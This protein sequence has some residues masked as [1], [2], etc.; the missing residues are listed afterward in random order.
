MLNHDQ[1]NVKKEYPKP[2]GYTADIAVFTIVATEKEAYKPPKMVLK[3]M[4]IQRA[5][6]NAEGEQNIEAGKWALPGGFVH[7]AES[8]YEAAKRELEEE[9][10]VAGIHMKQYGV[11][12]KPGRDARGWVISNAHYAIVPEE[13]LA[14]RQANDDAANV[15]LFDLEEVFSLPLAFDHAQIIQDGIAEIKK[16]L[17]Q[18]TVA[19]KFLPKMFTYSE[20]QAVLLTITDNPAIRSDQA[21]ARKIRMLPFIEEVEGQTT[22]RTS[23][24]PTKLYRFIDADFATSIYTARY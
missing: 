19:Q 12:D 13:M 1:K 14:K 5:I 3:L 9:T 10:G 15:E 6:L 4:L 23:K 16:D 24:K 18:T 7:P 22:T 20:L 17:L 8:A 11:Y 21:F 2:Y